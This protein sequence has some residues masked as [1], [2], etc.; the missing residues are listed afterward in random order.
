MPLHQREDRG[1]L[2]HEPYNI[3]IP[4]KAGIH[5]AS[6]RSLRVNMDPGRSLS[7]GRPEAGPGGRGDE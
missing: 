5:A 2:A 1:A 6:Q 7:S 3:V 4:A